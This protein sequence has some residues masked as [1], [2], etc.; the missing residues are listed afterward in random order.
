MRAGILTAFAGMVAWCLG[1]A[2]SA[3]LL[4]A[5]LD[6]GVVWLKAQQP[7]N[8]SYS[9][10]VDRALPEQSTGETLTVFHALKLPKDTA[11]TR[12]L[13]FLND[14]IDDDTETI[15][16]RIIANAQ[17][18][19]PTTA[20]LTALRSYQ[21]ADGGFGYI[22]G[23]ESFVF[24]TAWALKAFAAVGQLN[25]SEAQKALNELLSQ[26]KTDGHWDGLGGSLDLI[27]TAQAL[28]AIWMYRQSYG[29]TPYLV[30][31]QQWLMSQQSAGHWGD[32]QSNAHALRAVQLL[33][34]D[35]SSIQT[36]LTALRSAQS[37][38][39][40][41]DNDAWLTSLAL[42]ALLLAEAP[43][44][45]P[46][47]ASLKGVVLDSQTRSPLAGISVNLIGPTPQTL[48]TAAD[49]AFHFT[50]LTAGNYQLEIPA[51]GEYQRVLIDIQLGQG[52]QLDAGALL[53]NRDANPSTAILLGKVTR[54]DSGAPIVGAKVKAGLLEAIT[55][56]DGSYQIMGVLPGSM[57][58]EASFSGFRTAVGEVTAVAGQTLL[59]S[60]ALIPVGAN[61]DGEIGGTVLDRITQQPLTG[62]SIVIAGVFD[63]N[64]TTDADGKFSIT[65]IPAA[66]K[67]S[68]TATKTGYQSATGNVTVAVDS[69]FDFSP[70]LVPLGSSS[71]KGK[72]YGTVR[73]AD[74]NAP[75]SGVLVKAT[76]SNAST[77]TA[78]TGADGTYT[79]NNVPTGSVRIVASKTGYAQ[80]SAEAT[81]VAGGL[82][83]FSPAL[84]EQTAGLTASAIFGTVVKGSD[85]TPV[86]GAQVYVSGARS[87]SATADVNGHYRIEG[88]AAG[89]YTVSI[90]HSDFEQAN[91]NFDLPANTEMEFSPRLSNTSSNAVIVPN[92][93]TLS[94][95]LIDSV[96]LQPIA[97]ATYLIEGSA[98][99]R[100]V[101]RFGRFNIL[102]ITASTVN[103]TFSA[104]G[105]H[106]L[107]AQFAVFPLLQQDTGDVYLERIVAARL[108][109]LAVAKFDISGVS[110]DA[111]S[112]K[113]S[114]NAQVEVTNQGAQDTPHDISVLVFEDI[115]RDGRYTEGSDLAVGA[116]TITGGFTMGQTKSVTVAVNGTLR[117]RDAPLRL[118]I[119]SS[120]AV[121][122]LDENNNFDLYGTGPGYAAQTYTD[123][124]DF[125]LGRKIN[126]AVDASGTALKLAEN[127]RAF[128]NIWIANSGRGTILKIDI[129]TGQVTGEYRS[130]PLGMG[131][132]PS[133]TTVDK[134]GN[135]WVTNRAEGGYVAQD[136]IAPG[137]PAS[138]RYMG[139]VIKIGLAE[140]GQ[141]ISKHGDGVIRTST[142]LGDV[143]DWKN[144]G[145]VDRYGGTST[146][147][148]DCILEYVRVNSTGARH[149][150]VNRHNQ[151]WVSG[152]GYRNFD[153]LS[154]DG[155]MLRQEPTVG[156]GGYGGLIDANDI[157][158]SSSGGYGLLRWDTH[159]PLSGPNGGNWTGYN[160]GS[161]GL[162][163]DSKGN[164]WDSRGSVYRPDGTLL[165]TYVG[166]YQG[167]GVDNDDHVWV[168]NSSYVEHY[169]NDGVWIG[170]IYTG[171]TGG[172]TGL[173]ADANGKVW[174]A[175]GRTYVRIDP[176]A[177][178]IGADGVSPIGAIDLTGPDLGPSSY[179]YN[180]SDMTGST[181]SGKPKVGT[182]T[183]VHDSGTP[184]NKWGMINWHAQVLGDGNLSVTAATSDDCE[185]YSAAV[186]VTSGEALANLP[187]G[188][189]IRV[190]A[191]FKR[192]ST[193]ESPILYDLTVRPA[194]PDLTAAQ[195]RAVDKGFGNLPDVEALIGNA[196]PFDATDPFNVSFWKGDPAGGGTLLGTVSLPA[197]NADHSMHVTL[198]GVNL[199]LGDSIYV[200]ADSG[201]IYVE[202]N[203]TNNWT[204]GPL[205]ARNQRATLSV[206]T[207]QPSYGANEAVDLSGLAQNLGSFPADY[208]L[209]LT[210]RDTSNADTVAFSKV[211]LGTLAG[212]GSVS[213][214]QPWNTGSTRAGAYVLFGDLYN[215]DG[216]KVAEANAPF[217]IVTGDPADPL[218]WLRVITDKG[219]YYPDDGVDIEALAR[220]LTA[221][222]TID[223]AKVIL[224]VRD[225]ANSEVFTET[226][227]LGDL[228]PLGQRSGNT[229]QHLSA[230]T[231]GTY[232]VNAVLYN[233][234]DVEFARA[235]T[236][237]KVIA[238][239]PGNTLDLDGDV[240]VTRPQIQRGD[241]QHRNDTV[242]NVGAAIP[243]LNVARVLVE[244][245]SGTV[246]AR[247]EDS[248]ALAAGGSLS[249]PSIPIPT[250]GLADGDY[251]A[252][253]LAKDNGNWRALSIAP[254]I[255]KGGGGG[256]GG[257]GTQP[258][259]A[260][261][262]AALALL[263]ILVLL[264]S[265][266]AQRRYTKTQ[267]DRS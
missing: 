202:Y 70:Q 195:I 138:N 170:R 78:T 171:T 63:S 66:G 27:A 77:V 151:V 120:N 152:T 146:A 126:V 208:N 23:F 101:N 130:A 140:N 132:D 1:L 91:V 224:S 139:S 113:V 193:D 231:L 247:V 199:A 266:I 163:I 168:A 51:Q 34:S 86:A 249:W 88:L 226:L 264:L 190:S 79:F 167:C 156:W 3:D 186:T 105:Y 166:G 232:A 203:E 135:V 55:G 250:H 154:E 96:S 197:L 243:T 150:S 64:V 162:C 194:V 229:P 81:M 131:Q 187:A 129:N 33:L 142:G 109:D 188:Q 143:K 39:G 6:D 76:L 84:T 28:E 227:V 155:D 22:Q 89:N 213:H 185:H 225:P 153:L 67:I 236:H 127:V 42:G 53:L 206:A 209:Q 8:G 210:V 71:D 220:N 7:T 260:L 244:D 52:Q 35:T 148:D 65:P 104:P 161:Y 200:Q 17:Q 47:L 124:P 75:L 60:P 252:A 38:N 24:D 191:H 221:N 201:D 234:D 26:Q 134:N 56:N 175:G 235:G 176:S 245:A 106:T 58:V 87:Y 93:A 31:A 48:N 59:F 69:R 90:G 219:E 122:E 251:T 111:D 61:P 18:N 242:R 121:V 46:D 165:R 133:R 5:G 112:L 246:V 36:A 29:V 9:T 128:D 216:D 73:D 32:A 217:A 119:D 254:F 174:A 145:N 172:T 11:Q 115:D 92:S 158:W 16:R 262:P 110:T 141:C 108:P 238:L 144:T 240:S 50:A 136:A 261:D 44:P 233:G 13:G 72:L 30:K 223:A 123:K 241:P 222:L 147:E 114:G 198:S 82:M 25:S 183:V 107:I 228:N 10:A 267:G 184:G 83:E 37:A 95:R 100:G 116:A 204:N 263:L 117:Y 45:N 258:I 14:S 12:A 80:A 215:S 164:V 179:L 230:A 181:L 57:T 68:I 99:E 257:T 125:D 205:K 20:L 253:L 173:S 102:G 15:A 85:G 4:A 207:D 178:A 248:I 49:G 103:V 94:G 182:W 256:P 54:S 2:F 192:A 43:A 157:I 212:N 211:S 40:S 237:Y 97:N 214:H 239:P 159:N 98:Y 255:V 259:P 196:S 177:G 74:S 137:L 149:L 265:L 118:L 218:G 160:R 19:K 62:V 169:N 41:W 180:Y 189:C 21:N